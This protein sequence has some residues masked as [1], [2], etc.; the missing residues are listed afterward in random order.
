MGVK[1]C[2]SCSKGRE[3]VDGKSQ[4]KDCVDRSRIDRSRTRHGLTA[5]IYTSQRHRSSKRSHSHPEYDIDE[6]H[7]W[8]L[9]QELFHK[10]YNEWVES[11][12]SSQKRP[13]VDR[14]DDYRAYSLDNIQ[15]MTWDENRIKSYEDKID[16]KNNKTSRAV[17]Q[18]SL[19]GEFIE[20]FHSLAEAERITG[21]QRPNINHCCLGKRKWAGGFVWK[22]SD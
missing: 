8:L 3:S 17:N 10:L 18:Y 16:G 12:Y 1:I 6:L 20:R 9:S 22:F 21:V 5:C 7:E 15:L 11:G 14:I 13:S 2:N 4:C 19:E